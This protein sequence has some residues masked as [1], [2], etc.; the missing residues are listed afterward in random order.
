M[1]SL[2]YTSHSVQTGSFTT[3]YIEAGAGEPL[4]LIHGGGPGADCV[5]NW[6][7]CL[8]FFTKN[9]KV[10]AYDMVGFGQSDAPDLATFDYSMSDRAQQLIDFLEAKGIAG[11]ANVIGNSMG[12][13]ALLGAVMKRPG[14]VR[15][16]VLMGSAGLSRGVNPAAAKLMHYDFTLEG[17]R[18]VATALAFPGFALNEERIKYR[19]DLTMLDRVRR[20]TEGTMGWVKRNGGLH[21]EPEDIAA[22]KTRALVVHGKND[23]VVPVETAYKFLE[24]LEDSQGAI[25]QRCGHWAMLEH[26]ELFSRICTEFFETEG[27]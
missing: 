22:I 27:L 16:M 26:P 15:N 8:G 12:A 13:A 9:Y 14:L 24:L 23:L 1:S 6:T 7:D 4:V 5:G 2:E 11:K 17:M 3:H 25:L 10:Y 19:Y 21:Y 20:G 18:R